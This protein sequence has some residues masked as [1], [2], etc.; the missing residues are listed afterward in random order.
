MSKISRSVRVYHVVILFVTLHLIKV[1][2]AAK[3]LLYPK[4]NEL[5]KCFLSLCLN[6]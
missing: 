6:M 4:E 2:D 3:R 1:Y 5:S